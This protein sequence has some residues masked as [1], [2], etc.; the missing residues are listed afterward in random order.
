MKKLLFLIVFASFGFFAGAQLYT[1]TDTLV[2]P[3]GTDSIFS[4]NGYAKSQV[5]IEIDFRAADAFDSEITIG[6]TWTKWDTL[7]AAYQSL[8]NPVTLDL[9]NFPDSICR[10]ERTVGLPA[11]VLKIKVE[12]GRVTAGTKYPVKIAFD[13]F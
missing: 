1:F 3:V 5:Y 9:T 4:F 7:F 12:P 13:R 10:I 6:G 8:N 2:V 11:P